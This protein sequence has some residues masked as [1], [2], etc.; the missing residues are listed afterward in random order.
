[1]TAT[2]DHFKMFSFLSCKIKET[3]R[4][5]KPTLNDNVSSEKLIVISLHLLICKFL[6]ASVIAIVN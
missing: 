2:R 4:E 1:M 6:S 3:F 5:L